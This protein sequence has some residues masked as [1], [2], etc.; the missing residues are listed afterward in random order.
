MKDHIT[1]SEA[2]AFKARWTSVNL[3]EKR[4]LRTTSFEQKAKQLAAL[5]ESAEGM[6]WKETLASEESVVRDQIDIGRAD[7]HRLDHEKNPP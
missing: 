4:E 2:R 5:M 7:D 1:K 3:A 6:G